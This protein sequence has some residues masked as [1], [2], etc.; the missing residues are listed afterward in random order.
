MTYKRR[1]IA[2]LDLGTNTLL[3][4][5]AERN[6]SGVV[7]VLAD[8][9]AMPRL[10][11]GLRATGKIAPHVIKRTTEAVRTFVEK[12]KSL[13][14]DEIVLTAT[15]AAREAKNQSEFI[16]AVETAS[17][18]KLEIM[19]PNEEARL[20]YLSVTMESPGE[21]KTMVV[22][23]GGG[24]TEVTWGLGPRFDG[25]RSLNLGTIKLIEGP[26]LHFCP[27]S[28][29]LEQARKEID[30]QLARITPLGEFDRWAG[31]AGSFTHLASIDLGLSNYHPNHVAGHRLT[32]SKVD[33]WV[34]R[35][36]KMSR[37]EVL[38]LPGI[39]PRRAD[40][41]LAGAVIIERLFHK[42]KNNAFEVMDRGVR[43][44]KL[45]D[46]LHNFVP[47]VRFA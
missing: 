41:I 7:K 10:G 15:S 23:I 47:P 12:A 27:S 43:F 31:T 45:F 38:G 19:P 36:S 30:Q 29:D 16:S 20:T 33:E 13:G 22:D 44:G 34:Q 3:L 32:R 11:E 1:K 2:T 9:S 6:E 24:S 37:E 5:V 40:V 21:T 4:L 46:R 14:V 35:L 8:E 42:F 28:S 17:G 25:G 18:V 26:L 39:D